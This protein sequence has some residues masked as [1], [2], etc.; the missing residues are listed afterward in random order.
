MTD[1]QEKEM[2]KS[3]TGKGISRVKKMNLLMKEMEA[4]S[5]T[6]F[7]GYVKINYTQGSI[8]RVEKFEEILRDLKGNE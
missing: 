8:G 1:M 4:L 7:T 5:E 3:S 6:G 2:I